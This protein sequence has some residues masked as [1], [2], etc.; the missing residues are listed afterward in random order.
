MHGQQMEIDSSA[1]GAAPRLAG[2]PG[3]IIADAVVKCFVQLV[4]PTA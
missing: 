1:M 2:L 4:A 3:D